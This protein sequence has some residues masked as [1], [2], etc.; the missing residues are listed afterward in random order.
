MAVAEMQK[1]S[2]IL[3]AI[4]D[5]TGA[6]ITVYD[7]E[8]RPVAAYPEMPI[9]EAAEQ[10]RLPLTGGSTEIGYV[11][12][13]TVQ[14]HTEAEKKRMESAVRLI[15]AVI[16]SIGFSELFGPAGNSLRVDILRY[17]EK[18]LSEDL[19]V[20]TLCHRFSVSKSEL[21]RLLREVAPDGVAAY[22]RKKRIQRACQ[23]LRDTNKP[24]WRI[25]EE[26]GYDDHDY[27]QRAF[28]SVV[29]TSMSKYRKGI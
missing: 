22:I 11:L 4:H 27:F 16:T 17:I 25:A 7:R 14:P 10:L 24:V 29:G 19:S 15:E 13:E 12:V 9:A 6:Q 3:F 1:L 28:K 23:L 20:Q 21:Y 2:E 8:D 26:V 18:K 5:L